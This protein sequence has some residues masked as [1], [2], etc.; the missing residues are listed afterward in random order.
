ME[1]HARSEAAKAAEDSRCDF[2]SLAGGFGVR[3]KKTK[4]LK[5]IRPEKTKLKSASGMICDAE[6]R[7]ESPEE[8]ALRRVPSTAP[9]FRAIQLR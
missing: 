3:T 5:L 6:G 8:F 4:R 2:R 9:D 7:A 1:R